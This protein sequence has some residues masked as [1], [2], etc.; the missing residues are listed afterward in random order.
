MFEVILEYLRTGLLEIPERISTCENGVFRNSPT[1]LRAV[2]ASLCDD[3]HDLT[4]NTCVESLYLR[5]RS[6]T[7]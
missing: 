3:D 5:R 1:L 4:G 7:V 6:I 2:R